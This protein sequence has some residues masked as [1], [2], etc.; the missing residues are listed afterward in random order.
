MQYL[1]E[2]VLNQ[3]SMINVKVNNTN[4]NMIAYENANG[5]ITVGV[6]EPQ[7]KLQTRRIGFKK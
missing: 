5:K 4:V 7:T 6:I 2:D 1:R 3:A